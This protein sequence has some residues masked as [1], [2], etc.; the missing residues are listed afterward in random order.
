MAEQWIS[1][2]WISGQDSGS[3]RLGIVGARDS[4]ASSKATEV[5]ARL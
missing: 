5:A 1:W 3:H 4:M 2:V